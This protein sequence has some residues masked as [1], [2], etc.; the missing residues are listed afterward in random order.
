[1]GADSATE[2]DVLFG[3]FGAEAQVA[4]AAAAAAAAGYESKVVRTAF[5]GDAKD[6]L[7]FRAYFISLVG[8]NEW[9][10]GKAGAAQQDAML[11]SISD[12]VPDRGAVGFVCCFPHICKIYQFDPAQ[13]TRLCGRSFD[14]KQGFEV[15]GAPLCPAAR[16]RRTAKLKT[17]ISPDLRKSRPSVRPGRRWAALLRC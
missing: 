7:F 2:H 15:R 1:M 5:V 13:E 8:S 6:K 4:A 11:Q 16:P 3:A 10:Y 12:T 9:A 14:P 17:H